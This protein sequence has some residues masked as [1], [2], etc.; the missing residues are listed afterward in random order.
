MSTCVEQKA[1]TD[2]QPIGAIQAI[3][4]RASIR[5][6]TDRVVDEE[7]IA[8]LLHA[9]FCAPSAQNIR[10]WNF[11]VIRNGAIRKKLADASTYAKMLEHAP[12]V[13][14]ICGDK[15]KQPIPEFLVEDCA[16]AAENML[17][18]AHAIGLGAV[19]CGI[20]RAGTFIDEIS[21]ILQLPSNMI[22]T[23]LLGIGYPAKQRS[24]P[25]RFVAAQVHTDVW[26]NSQRN[27]IWG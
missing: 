26:S 11:I 5:S 23:M 6:Y 8:T 4:E 25:P 9:G 16:A 24:R 14:A 18:C 7:S 10:H 13:I 15:K 2:I 3:Q 21:K 27:E 12:V 19:W 1:E 17:L 20:T 22:P